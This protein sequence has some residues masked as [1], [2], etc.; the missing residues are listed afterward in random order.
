[1]AADFQSSN[2]LLETSVAYVCCLKVLLSFPLLQVRGA[3]FIIS[4]LTTQIRCS[5]ADA[6]Y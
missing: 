1:M 6:L 5:G 3:R 2:R 4:L